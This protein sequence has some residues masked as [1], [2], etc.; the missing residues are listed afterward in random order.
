MSRDNKPFIL[1]ILFTIDR[2]PNEAL[3]QAHIS[4]HMS[5][6]IPV[7]T[8][9]VYTQTEHLIIPS[10]QLRANEV[11]SIRMHVCIRVY[12]QLASRPTM[13]CNCRTKHK[14]SMMVLS[15]RS[16]GT[17][18]GG[19][20][21]QR[22]QKMSTSIT[23]CPARGRSTTTL[24]RACVRACVPCCAVRAVCAWVVWRA[25]C[26]ICVVRIACAPHALRRAASHC[27]TVWGLWRDVTW[28]L[29]PARQGRHSFG[30]CCMCAGV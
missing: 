15:N 24:V 8:C 7:H 6:R 20:A 18:S 23:C 16:R 13:I 9:M 25:L 26:V 17:L 12:T 21:R 27:I 30:L 2:A 10:P 28:Q 3:G 4:A 1:V 11:T 14:T 22:R 19:K 29:C 5:M